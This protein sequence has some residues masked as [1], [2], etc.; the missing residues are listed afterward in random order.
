MIIPPNLEKKWIPTYFYNI[1][2]LKKAPKKKKEKKIHITVITSKV[3]SVVIIKSNLE[4]G[5]CK[6]KEVDIDAGPK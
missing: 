4:K 3:D 5:N 2:V 6:T 1:V